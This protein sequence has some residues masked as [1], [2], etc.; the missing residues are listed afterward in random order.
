MSPGERARLTQENASVRQQ[1]ERLERTVGQRDGTIAA[2]HQQIRRLEGFGPERPADLFAPV[3]LEIAK[4]SGGHDYDGRRGDDGVTVYLRPRDADGD[5][6]KV[7]GRISVQ[8][9]DNTEL[10]SPKVIAVCQL[11]D[12]DGLREAWYGQFGTQH[13]TLKCPFPPGL[14]PPRRVDVKAEF[15]DY[16]TGATLTAV[17]EVTVSPVQE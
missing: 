11:D 12:A 16:L 5:V 13:Y 17:K 14:K 3:R 6:V 4:L 2:L 10:D 8:L 7:P 1:K 15:V 9:L